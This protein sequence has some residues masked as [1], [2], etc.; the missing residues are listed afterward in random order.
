MLKRLFLISIVLVL[1]I[2][3]NATIISFEDEDTTI[4]TTPGS[5]VK[6][7][8]VTDGPLNFLYVIAGV[9]GDVSITGAV[10]I[11]DAAAYGWDPSLSFD[12]LI[13]S[14]TAE[15]GMGLFGSSN[16]GPV[17]G[18]LEVT[19]GSGTVVVSGNAPPPPGSW[20]A[21][22]PPPYPI[23]STGVVTIV[24]EPATLLLLALG[25]LALIKKRNKLY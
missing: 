12:P 5:I 4:S 19:Y 25:G 9:E 6:L 17:V 13:T 1:S 3:A 11:A 21:I 15:I 14:D 22:Y 18:Y 16:N 7:N 24:P 10:G 2:H 23:F 8:I 20:P